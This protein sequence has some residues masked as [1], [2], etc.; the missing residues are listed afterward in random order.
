M[1]I[2]LQ[3]L[4]CLTVP[5]AFSSNAVA[6]PIQPRIDI[7]SNT[8]HFRG[9]A[10]GGSDHAR[11]LDVTPRPLG[12]FT[13]NYNDTQRWTGDPLNPLFYLA[14]IDEQISTN[15]L[16][17]EISLSQDGTYILSAPNE[18]LPNGMGFGINFDVQFRVLSG[19]VT[20]ELFYEGAGIFCCRPS[21]V[22]LWDAGTDFLLTSAVDFGG[23]ARHDDFTSGEQVSS[24][25]PIPVVLDPGTYRMSIS[26]GD[27]V[28]NVG[29]RWEQ[30][31]LIY[32]GLRVIGAAP[33]AEPQS[34]PLFAMLVAM[35]I[36]CRRQLSVRWAKAAK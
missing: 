20:I 29:G 3:G 28:P 17:S 15:L 25:A 36:P 12:S 22:H 13:S 27:G 1:S 24:G 30:H 5:I 33:V 34:L 4:L 6:A 11:Y 2:V 21:E 8:V 16:D 18:E 35:L 32:A 7:T 9:L 14:Q 10:G 26:N 19:P 23:G 31:T